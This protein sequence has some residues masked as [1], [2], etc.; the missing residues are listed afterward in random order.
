MKVL[1]HAYWGKNEKNYTCTTGWPPLCS[2]PLCPAL[3][4]PPWTLHRAAFEHT[5]HMSPPFFDLSNVFPPNSVLKAELRTCPHNSVGSACPHLLPGA[6]CPSF[7][8]W[9]SP[10]PSWG[11]AHL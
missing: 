11:P 6:R 10:W 1:L 4:M 5:R 7:S 9:S 3:S 2:V 8:F